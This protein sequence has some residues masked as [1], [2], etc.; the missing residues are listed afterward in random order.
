LKRPDT[1][2]ERRRRRVKPAQVRDSID[3]PL[4]NACVDRLSNGDP[5]ST[6][7]SPNYKLS[8]RR[9]DMP[10]VS[11]LEKGKGSRGR[12]HVL[13]GHGGLQGGEWWLQAYERL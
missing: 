6:S 7:H 12:G 10:K 5:N 3:L 9:K 1:L 13:Q 4:E 11:I 8:D 2:R